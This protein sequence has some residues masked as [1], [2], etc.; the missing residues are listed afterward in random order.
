MQ[1]FRLLMLAAMTL[2][3]LSSQAAFFGSSCP[4]AVKSEKPK[5][6]LAGYEYTEPGYRFGFGESR[7]TKDHSFKE[8]LEKAEQYARQDLVSSVHITVDASS[9]IKTLVEKNTKGENISYQ[10]VTRV[11]IHS[12]LELPG[13]P[14]YRQW[15]DHESCSVYLQVRISEPIL[16]LVL[17]KTQTNS[18]VADAN[19]N[20]KTIRTRIYAIDEAILLAKKYEF[21]AIPSNLTSAQMLRKFDNIRTDLIQLSLRNNHA[22]YIVTPTDNTG[23]LSTLRNKIK[24]SMSGSFETEVACSS[25]SMCLKQAGTTSANYASIAVIDLNM[26]KQNSFWVGDFIVD[27]TLWDLSDKSRQF[28]IGKKSSRVMHRYKHKLTLDRGLDK[29]LAQHEERMLDYIEHA[30]SRDL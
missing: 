24:S 27:I 3:T 22:V 12:K 6:V 30:K 9:G 7:Y 13:L 1:M 16:D 8:L 23:M 25:A 28:S 26:S 5:W 10:Q 11:E 2:L 18:Y 19:N 29:W 15:Q 4:E 20:E 14:I 21:S 17:K